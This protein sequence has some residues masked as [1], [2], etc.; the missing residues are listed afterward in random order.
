MAVRKRKWKGKNG[1]LRTAWVADYVD[2]AGHRHVKTFEK[3]K[4]AD[5]YYIK[6]KGEVRQ[7][8]HTAEHN[9]VTVEQA[10][11]M[12]LASCKH[13]RLRKKRGA[14]SIRTKG[15]SGCI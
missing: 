13:A 11:E 12:Y 4:E 9:S 7:G 10:G 2:Q 6:V 1:E 8:I 14:L 3:K 15:C 5:E